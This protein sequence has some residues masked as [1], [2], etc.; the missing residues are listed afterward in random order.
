[1][2]VTVIFL[3]LTFLTGYFGMNFPR[4]WTIRDDNH[5]DALYVLSLPFSL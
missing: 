4:M 1:M 2:L 5:S 3:P